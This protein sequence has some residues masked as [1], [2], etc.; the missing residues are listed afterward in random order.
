[1]KGRRNL[2]YDIRGK[3]KKIPIEPG[4]VLRVPRG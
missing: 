4:E 3:G 1:L 2:Y